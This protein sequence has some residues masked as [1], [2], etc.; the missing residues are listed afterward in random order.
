MNLSLFMLA[1]YETTSTTLSYCTYILAKYP[2]EQQKLY[3]EISSYYID[4]ANV[5]IYRKIL[6][7]LSMHYIFQSFKKKR[8]EANLSEVGPTADNV[9]KLEY[10][11][12]FIKEVLR[13]YP[14]GNR[15]VKLKF[16][17]YFK[18]CIII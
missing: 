11:D 15:L 1:G 7:Y 13:M 17:N 9:N 4:D 12:M 16:F 18:F 14:I 10:L 2:D 8:D 6:I 5:R 3:D